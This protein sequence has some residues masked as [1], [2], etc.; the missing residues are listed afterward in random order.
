VEALLRLLATGVVAR[1]AVATEA[2]TTALTPRELVERLDLVTV[3]TVTVAV[4]YHESLAHLT[5]ILL[6]YALG[7]A[8]FRAVVEAVLAVTAAAAFPLKAYVEVSEGFDQAAIAACP[9]A[10][11]LA[12]RIGHFHSLT[13]FLDVAADKFLGILFQNRVD[14]VEQVVDVLGDLGVAL[15]YL[16]VGLN[17]DVLDLLVLPALAGLRLSAG[18]SGCHRCPPSQP[19]EVAQHRVGK[20]LPRHY[21]TSGARARGFVTCS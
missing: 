20:N 11:R 1:L 16:R 2:T 21:D 10:V 4:R 15:G 12:R 7:V 9:N 13:A 19:P 14:F 5:A 8:P 3:G 6:G 18:V 17:G